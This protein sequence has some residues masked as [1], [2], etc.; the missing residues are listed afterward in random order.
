[1]RLSF[2]RLES[3]YGFITEV[4]LLLAGIFVWTNTVAEDVVHFL[5]NWG[6]EYKVANG[7]VFLLIVSFYSAIMKAPFE[8]YRIV[9]IDS[10]FLKMDYTNALANWIWDQLKLSVLAILVGIP[11]L[12]LILKLV[13]HF[14]PIHW[15][16][17]FSKLFIESLVLIFSI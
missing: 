1:M 15:V 14:D 5:F 17:Y 11:L 3:T 8:I 13:S 9:V 2:S 12:S 7:V 10:K 4:G 6:P 16:C